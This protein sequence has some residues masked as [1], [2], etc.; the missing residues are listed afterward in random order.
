[1]N[2]PQKTLDDVL[3]SLSLPPDQSWQVRPL[4]LGSVS[5]NAFF[6]GI[7]LSL[8]SLHH[9]YK[10]NHNYNQDSG[11]D[12]MLLMGEV[13]IKFVSHCNSSCMCA[14]LRAQSCLNPWAIARQVSLF[15]KFSRQEY[16]SGLPYP[17]SGDLPGP[18]IKP[19]SLLSP[20]LAGGF[21]TTAPPGK[22]CISS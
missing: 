2:I 5:N 1:M 4:P 17:T 19:L 16:W 12:L 14:C 11:S 3:P 6:N 7:V 9:F 8:S 18:G 21:F 20:T 22:P 13:V 10:I 15:M